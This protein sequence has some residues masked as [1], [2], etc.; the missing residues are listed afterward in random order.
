MIAAAAVALAVDTVGGMLL[1]AAGA[2][3]LEVG[4]E[5]VVTLASFDREEVEVTCPC[6]DRMAVDAVGGMPFEAAGAVLLLVDAKAVV[7]L[8]SFD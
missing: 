3:L 1:E 7:T 2:V 4:A 6:E 5:A 8:A